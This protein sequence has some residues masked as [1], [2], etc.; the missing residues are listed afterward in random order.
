M[1]APTTPQAL[2][3]IA[4][5]TRDLVEIGAGDG[6]WAKALRDYGVDVKAFDISPLGD[7]LYGSHIDAAPH[8]DSMLA[9]WPPDG[10]PIQQWI[11]VKRWQTIIIVGSWVR[12]DVGDSL[13][14]YGNV[15]TIDLPFGDKACAVHQLR[16]YK[17]GRVRPL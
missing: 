15:D 11:E 14:D 4:K 5:H 12:I 17:H 1:L 10:T 13:L 2:H 8:S 7:V 9:V 6:A 16:V 3:T